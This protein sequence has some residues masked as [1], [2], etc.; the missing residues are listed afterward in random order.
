MVKHGGR[1]DVRAIPCVP[2]I[3]IGIMIMTEARY[4][5]ASLYSSIEPIH[6]ARSNLLHDRKIGFN[7]NYQRVV[8]DIIHGLGMSVYHLQSEGTVGL[9]RI[10]SD[11]LIE[12]EGLLA[13]P[14][15]SNMALPD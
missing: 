1:Q 10:C 13:R 5:R 12:A 7:R 11:C 3:S 6:L 8:R 14:R 4:L 2:G 15:V 9:Y